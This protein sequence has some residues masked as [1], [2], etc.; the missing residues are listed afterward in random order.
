[1][2]W[3]SDLRLIITVTTVI[4]YVNLLS[5]HFKYKAGL[6]NSPHG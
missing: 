1:M 3:D 6:C 4:L 5:L 2:C